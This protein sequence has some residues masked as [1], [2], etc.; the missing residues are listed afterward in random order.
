MYYSNYDLEVST[1][2]EAKKKLTNSYACFMDSVAKFVTIADFYE[3]PENE[4]KMLTHEFRDNY[5]KNYAKLKESSVDDIGYMMADH[6]ALYIEYI[7]DIKENLTAYNE[8]IKGQDET[9]SEYDRICDLLA[10]KD[11]FTDLGR[12]LNKANRIIGNDRRLD[13]HKNDPEYDI[14]AQLLCFENPELEAIK[15]EAREAKAKLKAEEE[16]EYQRRYAQDNEYDDEAEETTEEEKA[17]TEEEK[18]PIEEEVPSQ[19]EDVKAE[20]TTPVTED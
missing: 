16:A 1:I 11:E 4:G 14:Q 20:E 10:I 3:N 12:D 6:A 17:E 2:E 18:A 5:L 15:K 19:E 8:I 7:E 9:L 13:T